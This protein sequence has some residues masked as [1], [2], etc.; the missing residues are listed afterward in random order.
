MTSAV[1]CFHISIYSMNTYEYMVFKRSCHV[2]LLYVHMM[3][4][5]QE[6]IDTDLRP[7]LHQVPSLV[8]AG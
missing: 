8:G 2:L 4:A 1:E 5:H 6:L 3:H 7:N